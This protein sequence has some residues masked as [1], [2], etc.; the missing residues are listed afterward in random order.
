MHMCT[1]HNNL[2]YHHVSKLRMYYTLQLLHETCTSVYESYGMTHDAIRVSRRAITCA[3]TRAGLR[4]GQTGQLPGAP[5][6]GG[7]MN[8]LR[9]I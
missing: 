7:P 1:L 9:N 4:G 8:Y 6:F 2:Q 3:T 5:H